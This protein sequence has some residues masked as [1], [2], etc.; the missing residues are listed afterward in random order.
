MFPR[1][2]FAMFAA[3]LILGLLLAFGSGK[4]VSSILFQVGAL[5]PFAFAVAPIIL[6]AAA[7]LATWLPTRRALRI[8]PIDA[9]RTE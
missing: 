1:E 7:L 9:L 5:D 4:V 2:G 8:N 6:A 3:G